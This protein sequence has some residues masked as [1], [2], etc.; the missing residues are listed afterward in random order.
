MRNGCA[1]NEGRVSSSG[2]LYFSCLQKSTTMK[3]LFHALLIVVIAMQ[4][5]AP[6]Q[7]FQ[8]AQHEYVI[9]KVYAEYLDPS[10]SEGWWLFRD[11][12]PFDAEQI[13]HLQP[14]LFGLT[15]DDAMRWWNTRMDKA[16]NRHLRYTQYH[17]GIRVEGIELTVH[18]RNGS[19]SLVNGKVATHLPLTALPA[20][21]QEQAVQSALQAVPAAVYLWED[22]VAEGRFRLRQKS[23]TAT[24]YPQPELLFVKTKTRQQPEYRLAWRMVIAAKLPNRTEAVYVDAVNGEVLR[25][26]NLAFHCGTVNYWPDFATTFN[27]DQF[28][29]VSD[30]SCFDGYVSEA[31]YDDCVLT[32]S[33]EYSLDA[34]TGDPY[35]F[36]SIL[37]PWNNGMQ[38]GFTS[39]YAVDQVMDA[40]SISFDHEGFSGTGDVVDV[41][42]EVVFYDQNNQPYTTS[43]SFN[44]FLDNINLGRGAT[45]NNVLDDY[46]TIDIVGHEFT[47]GIINDAHFDALDL[48][49]EA[50][51]VNEALCDLFGEFSNLSGL[52]DWKLGAEKSDGAIRHYDNPKAYGDPDTYLGDYWYSGSGDFG[53]IHTNCTVL[54]HC[55]YLMAEGGT[56]INDLGEPYS[57]TAL[58]G[59]KWDVYDIAWQA[60]MNYIDGDDDFVTTRNCFIQ[61]AIDLFGSC[62]ASVITVGDAFKAVGITH[63]SSEA[64]GSICGSYAS[65][66]PQVVEGIMAVSNATVF[67]AAYLTPCNTT[68]NAGANVTVKGSDYINLVPG[69][70][71]KSGSVFTGYINSCSVS[72]Y[73]PADL[74]WTMP[75]QPE[76]QAAEEV[77]KIISLF[78]NPASSEALITFSTGN[79]PYTLLITDLAG[80]VLQ[81]ISG[82]ETADSKVT[83]LRLDISM[84]PDGCYSCILKCDDRLN[85]E[86]LM[87]LH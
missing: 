66:I 11:R 26:Q 52:V 74:R 83:Q 48:E 62:S 31:S 36:H 86:K 24:L 7:S 10:S 23:E 47:H 81:E 22:P 49:G 38:M 28:L 76:Q 58:Q 46:N 32:N 21:T 40:F 63:Y 8:P 71:A 68:I 70:T 82:Q 77:K 18:E 84:L 75:D 5:E 59:G 57:V 65:P 41:Y 15:G 53:G 39:L 56:G 3:Y 6:A 73:N 33:A 27:G 64:F 60:M 85:M 29:E 17:K 13:L 9:P 1:G 35:C 20:I 30:E 79:K 14:L 45:Y 72:K 25:T 37:L 61:A 55:F 87:V 2:S 4:G 80:K 16:G 44:S 67:N 54:D 78:P 69:F 43:A 19:V 42:N 34:A 51:G 12:A 50:G